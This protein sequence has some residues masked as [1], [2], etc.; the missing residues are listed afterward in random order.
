MKKN[1]IQ[2]LPYF[3]PHIWG[4]EKVWEDIFLYWTHWS[5]LIYSWNMCQQSK[6]N[7][8]RHDVNNKTSESIVDTHNKMFFPSYEIIDNFPS[9]SLWT[10][11]F[12]NSYKILKSLIRELNW[13]NK[14]ELIIITHTR[15]FL[16]SF[17]GWIIARKYKIKWVHL[18]HGSDYVLLSSKFKNKISYL[19]D[20]IIWK[21]I[22][23]SADTVLCISQ[24][25]KNF[26]E[27]EFWRTDCD[28]WYRWMN[29]ENN[30]IKKNSN[31]IKVIFIWRLVK[32]KWVSDLLHA[33]VKIQNLE[34]E[35][36]WDGEERNNL[37]K[38][39]EKLWISHR[40]KFLWFKERD[41]IVKYLSENNC[42]V[43]NPSYQEW[44]PTTVIESLS[45]K[46]VSIASN[47]GWTSE[48]SD[49]EDLI[50]FHAGEI[51]LLAEKIK[52][53][54]QNYFTLEWKSYSDVL[55]K[56]GMTESMNSLYNKI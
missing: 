7:T 5:S 55:K 10:K 48:I 13:E 45:T 43:I 32:L 22:L 25:S 19:Y 9:P 38:L 36:I 39:C 47:V 11:K 30:L 18:E 8:T 46:N 23:N 52:Y 54:L 21:W 37:H 34:I 3:P 50:L 40:V 24:A 29:L 27:K 15:F 51:E 4:L 33:I 56:F 35:I 12:W 44:L 49:K 2:I 20:R 1:I 6:T 14:N 26:V 28:I 53:A 16:S 42:I 31:D 41:F 17:M